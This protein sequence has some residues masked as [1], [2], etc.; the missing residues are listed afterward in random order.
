MENMNITPMGLTSENASAY[1]GIGLNLLRRL[2]QA[3]KLPAL[4]VGARIII[5]RDVLDRF[6]EVNLGV[7][8]LDTDSVKPV[9]IA[10]K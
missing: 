8:L 9:T 2:V 6:L 7:D 3:G 10:S 5:K 1:S 4:R